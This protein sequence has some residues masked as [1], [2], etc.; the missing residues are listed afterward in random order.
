MAQR[1]PNSTAWQA[2]GPLGGSFYGVGIVFGLIMFGYGFW[3]AFLAVAAM[4]SHYLKRSDKDST[5]ARAVFHLGFW[6]T[7][8]SSY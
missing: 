1:H 3:F 8:V 6:A 5:P 7:T 4:C 2:L